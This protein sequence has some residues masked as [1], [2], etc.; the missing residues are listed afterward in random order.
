MANEDKALLLGA[1][2]RQLYRMA[3]ALE[4][5]LTELG[6]DTPEK[7]LDLMGKVIHEQSSPKADA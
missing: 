4:Q 6:Y 2:L 3:S 5:E 1:R 7:I